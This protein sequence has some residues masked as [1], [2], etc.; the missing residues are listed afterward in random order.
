MGLPSYPFFAGR[1]VDGFD[2]SHFCR[3]CVIP[4][5]AGIQYHQSLLDSGLRRSDVV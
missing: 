1:K 3:I 2:K 4:A 5:K